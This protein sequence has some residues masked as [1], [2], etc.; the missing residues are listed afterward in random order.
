M[1]LY[2]WISLKKER[3]SSKLTVKVKVKAV[4]LYSASSWTPQAGGPTVPPLMR[5]RHGPGTAGRT[6][7][8]PQPAQTCLGSNPTADQTVPVK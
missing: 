5:F 3:I 6:G 7:H 4:D 8:C 1:E 2:K